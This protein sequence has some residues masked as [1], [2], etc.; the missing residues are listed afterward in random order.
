MPYVKP[1]DKNPYFHIIFPATFISIFILFM[2]I[3]ANSM[4][5]SIS[6]ATFLN[7]TKNM[8]ISNKEKTY[9][10]NCALKID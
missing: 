4:S 7:I 6:Y 9:L 3:C 2:D 10:K 5:F 1:Y 8:L